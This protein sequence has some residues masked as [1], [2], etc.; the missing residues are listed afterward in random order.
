[1]NVCV[2]PQTLCELEVW[3][4]GFPQNGITERGPVRDF[5]QQQLHHDGKLVRRLLEANGRVLSFP[6]GLRQQVY[7]TLLHS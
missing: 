2:A 7:I 3:N 6:D 4:E 1:M 5:P